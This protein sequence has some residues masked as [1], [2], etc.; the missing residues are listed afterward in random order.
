MS[1]PVGWFSFD[2]PYSNIEDIPDTA[3][4]FIILSMKNSEEILMLDVDQALEMRSGIRTHER[5]P[6][7]LKYCADQYHFAIYSIPGSRLSERDMI[8]RE[9]R[10]Q[11]EFPCGE[12]LDTAGS[13][14]CGCG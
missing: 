3:G 14:C 6:C 10:L 12:K 8:V 9:I 1:I 7:W 13:G 11:Y 4:I 5:I 2:G